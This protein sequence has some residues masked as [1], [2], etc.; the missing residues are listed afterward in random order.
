MN[1][2]P[3]HLYFV[4]VKDGDGAVTTG[5]GKL[6]TN[7]MSRAGV[8]KDELEGVE[9]GRGDGVT[10]PPIS[11]DRRLP[12]AGHSRRPFH[13]LYDEESEITR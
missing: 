11:T 13:A 2:S 1:G 4:D 10:Y 3:S 5:S 6:P 8:T 12:T 7:H 9:G